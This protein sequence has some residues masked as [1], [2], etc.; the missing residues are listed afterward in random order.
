MENLSGSASEESIGSNP[1][2]IIRS[3][4]RQQH[5]AAL[6]AERSTLLPAKRCGVACR[7]AHDYGLRRN[8]RKNLGLWREMR[9]QEVNH[10]DAI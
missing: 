3:N 10:H 6:P 1:S 2:R 8:I 5:L 9:T 4:G 7:S